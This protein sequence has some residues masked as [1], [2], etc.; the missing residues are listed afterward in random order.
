MTTDEKW[1]KIALKE[2]IKAELMD[3]VPVGGILVK[4]NIIIAQ[5]HNQPIM[6]HDATAHAEIQLLRIAGEK[7]KNYRLPNTTLYVTLEPCIMCFSAMINAR[8]DRV[9]FG[10]YDNKIGAY[11]S[12]VNLTKNIHFNHKISSQGGVLENESRELLQGFF[13]K[14]RNT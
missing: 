5:A 2:A 9:V 1:M 6:K 13:N 14:R 7:E 11:S 4:K 10:A 8:I 12:I 3:E